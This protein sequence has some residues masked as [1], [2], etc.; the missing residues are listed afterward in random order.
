M[1]RF[2]E[3]CPGVEP[4]LSS[5]KVFDASANTWFYMDTKVELHPALS[6]FKVP[7]DHPAYDEGNGV[8][9]RTSVDIAEDTLLG[10][11]TGVWGPEIPAIDNIYALGVGKHG[12]VDGYSAG[13]LLRCINDAHGIK[14]K[15]CNVAFIS[16]PIVPNPK[17]PFIYTYPVVALTNIKAGEEL[18]ISYGKAYWESLEFHDTRVRPGRVYE[19]HHQH[20]PAY[21]Q[22]GTQ[23]D[24]IY[25]VVAQKV[26]YKALEAQCRFI[27]NDVR[28]TVPLD[29]LKEP[30]RQTDNSRAF[31]PQDK[32]L[33]HRTPDKWEPATVRKTKMLGATL[34]YDVCM[35]TNMGFVISNVSWAELRPRE[36]YVVEA[37]RT[38][39]GK[40]K[41]PPTVNKEV[42]DK[43][44]KSKPD[45][46]PGRCGKRCQKC[47]LCICATSGHK[48]T[49]E[50]Q[51]G[52]ECLNK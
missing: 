44:K 35:D 32:V 4:L 48:C 30:H 20:L 3:F 42:K 2:Q 31:A 8:G 29:A 23:A 10:V 50:C 22:A 1:D 14:G 38:V 13:N 15:K 45:I 41:T 47:T 18:F 40:R 7:S 11:Y 52:P 19:V 24:E 49:D 27:C 28:F 17:Y 9:V 34:S 46:A 16:T 21:F 43:D 51:C 36:A 25:V 5:L 26:D 12:K 39:E 6:L 37:R 33:Y